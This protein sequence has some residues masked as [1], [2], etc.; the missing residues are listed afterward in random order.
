MEGHG[1]KFFLRF[2]NFFD[3]QFKNTS[4][5]MLLSFKVPTERFFHKVF[6]TGLLA[7]TV[8]L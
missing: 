7:S 2:E 6:K 4:N 8:Y 5:L 3:I 1:A